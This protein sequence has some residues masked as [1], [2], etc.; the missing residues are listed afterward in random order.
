MDPLIVDGALLV[1]LSVASKSGGSADPSDVPPGTKIGR[2]GEALRAVTSTGVVHSSTK[3]AT[4][5]RT[6]VPHTGLVVP[7]TPAPVR[8][9][10]GSAFDR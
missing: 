7:P 6:F 9:K 5:T 2:T 8:V 1:I 4:L 10:G 3:K